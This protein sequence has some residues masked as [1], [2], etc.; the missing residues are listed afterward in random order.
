MGG[1][2][3]RALHFWFRCSNNILAKFKRQYE[4]SCKKTHLSVPERSQMRAHHTNETHTHGH[5]LAT[6]SRAS[7]HPEWCGM[8][9]HL[10]CHSRRTGDKYLLR[11][12]A[13]VRCTLWCGSCGKFARGANNRTP[14][15]HTSHLTA[16]DGLCART[17]HGFARTC[18]QLFGACGNPLSAH[19]RAYHHKMRFLACVTNKPAKI[20][21]MCDL[22]F[23]Q[24]D[25]IYLYRSPGCLSH[26]GCVNV[27]VCVCLADCLWACLWR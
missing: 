18:S 15:T 10:F 3:K 13:R 22:L 16:A 14:S 11:C 7:A 4:E 2:R 6:I 8:R 12:V 1:A 17:P 27:C 9:A 20:F 5:P 24:P 25:G 23:S 26:S 19:I 21:Y